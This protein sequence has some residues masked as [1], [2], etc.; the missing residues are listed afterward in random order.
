MGAKYVDTVLE[1]FQEQVNTLQA[2]VAKAEDAEEIAIIFGEFRE[3]VMPNLDRAIR[4]SYRN[5][6]R[7]AETGKASTAAASPKR[8]NRFATKR[9]RPGEDAKIRQ[10]ES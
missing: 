2:E 5:G 1:E 7:D 4:T 10:T 6:I 9:T 8:G 3:V